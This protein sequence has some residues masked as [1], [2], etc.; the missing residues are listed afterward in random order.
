MPASYFGKLAEGARLGDW[1]GFKTAGRLFATAEEIFALKT[2]NPNTG[3]QNR[4]RNAND[5]P[6]DPTFWM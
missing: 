3:A 4:Y 6:G 2:I 5:V 1:Y